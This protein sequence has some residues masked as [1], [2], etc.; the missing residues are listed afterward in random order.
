MDAPTANLPQVP[1]DDEPAG[2]DRALL[3]T[4]HTR[5]CGRAPAKRGRGML[6]VSLIGA[7]V[8]VAAA[9]VTVFLV[10]GPDGQRHRRGGATGGRWRGEPI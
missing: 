9:A 4:L 7:L 10:L 6:I 1:A 5:Q 8:A 3:S 2:S